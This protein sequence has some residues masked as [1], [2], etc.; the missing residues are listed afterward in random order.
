VAAWV[1][2]LVCD[3]YLMKNH[4]FAD[5]VTTTKAGEKIS[6]DLASLELFKYIDVGLATFENNQILRNKIS[7]RYVA[8]NKL[9]IECKILIVR[10]KRKG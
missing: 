6:T 1:P 2:D 3:F 5:N 7:R 10:A 4:K 9:Y 8:T